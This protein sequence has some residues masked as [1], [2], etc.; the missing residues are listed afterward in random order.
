MALT[1]LLALLIFLVPAAASAVSPA[2]EP[3]RGSWGDPWMEYHSPVTSVFGLRE[4]LAAWGITP[5]AR[6]AAD[7]QANVLGGL[8]RGRAYAGELGVDLDFDLEKIAGLRGLRLHTSA[9]W[10]SGTDL[11][12]DVGN[13]F[14]VAQYFEGRQ[15][16]LATMFLQQSLFGGRLELKVGRFG[17]GDNFF[18]WPL[19]TTLVNEAWTIGLALQYNV[20]TVTSDPNVTWGG[21]V[22]VRPSDTVSVQGA[23]FYSD[24]TLDQTTANGTEFG[25]STKAG[26]FL[27][28]EAAYYPNQ[29]KGAKGLPGRY[30]LGGYYDSNRYAFF[31]DPRRNERGKFGFYL[32]GD[33]MVYREPGTEDGQGLS[34]F[35]G[36][37]Y[38]PRERTNLLPYFATAGATYRGLIPKR[39]DDTATFALYYGRFSRDL[40]DRTY[41]LT[42]EWTYAINVAPWLIVQP[43]VQYVIQPGGRSSIGNAL[44]VGLQLWMSF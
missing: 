29:E 13:A 38:A 31:D 9:D 5:S 37:L 36:F 2:D 40:H 6:Y 25:I 22:I 14:T 27:I 32:L 30:R 41:E 44:V 21:R 16:R 1:A 23:V 4:T 33:Q 18:T 19:N 8:R 20:P 10:A 43:D 42:L 24:P 26:Y 34:L 12:R 28:G 39:D 7:L 35:G 3:A 15:A 11:S 17:T